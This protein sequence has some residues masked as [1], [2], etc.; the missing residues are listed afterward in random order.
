MTNLKLYES[1][2]EADSF[3]KLQ[4]ALVNVLEKKAQEV[5]EKTNLK[6]NEILTKAYNDGFQKGYVA[7][8][9]KAKVENEQFLAK[10]QEEFNKKMSQ[11]ENSLRKVQEEFSK[12]LKDVLKMFL[13][14]FFSKYVKKSIEKEKQIIANVLDEASEFI[15]SM[16]IELVIKKEYEEVAK[17]WLSQ[18]ET[19]EGKIKL[20]VSDTIQE[21]AII[22]GKDLKVKIDFDSFIK[23]LVERIIV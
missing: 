14:S 12:Y 6:V 15:S 16:D 3:D 21:D 10:M 20:T 19:K 4:D 5:I 17:K 1:N 11:L 9:E 23:T 22:L 8:Q 2:W 7:G 18:F 13:V